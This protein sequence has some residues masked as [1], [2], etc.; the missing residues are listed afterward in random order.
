MSTTLYVGNI[1][2]DV[3]KSDLAQLFSSMGVVLDADLQR[4]WGSM[5]LS[6]YVTMEDDQS[7]ARAAAVFD[8]HPLFGQ[9]LV[10]QSTHRL[11]C[12]GQG[13]RPTWLH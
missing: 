6:G 4:T 1:A 10:V 2:H 9:A 11:V 3:S 8:G 13:G 7:A 12:R 5:E